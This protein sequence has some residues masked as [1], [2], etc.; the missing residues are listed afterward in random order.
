MNQLRSLVHNLETGQYSNPRRVQREV[1]EIH[2]DI[3]TQARLCKD[4]N[5]ESVMKEYRVL[6]RLADQRLDEFTKRRG[7]GNSAVDDNQPSTSAAAGIPPPSGEPKKKKKKSKK[8]KNKA[9]ESLSPYAS[10]NDDPLPINLLARINPAP[11]ARP[12]RYNDE[13]LRHHIDA[14]REPERAGAAERDPGSSRASVVSNV[15]YASY[16]SSV[17]QVFSRPQIG[18]P[19]PPMSWELPPNSGLSRNDPGIVGRSEIYTNRNHNKGRCS[20]CNGKHKM[21]RCNNFVRAGLQERWFMALKL[22]VC[23]HC[24]FPRHSSFT[25]K[26]QS[27]CGRCGKRHNSLLCPYNPN[28]QNGEGPAAT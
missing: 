6:A 10:D 9:K 1:D 12:S 11:N 21:Y 25:C 19:Y 28:N 13:D 2:V 27:A 4:P 23:L 16:I 18:V 17:Q 26:E 8:N 3:Q 15:S 14:R 5:I 24:L 20:W 22:G 7:Q